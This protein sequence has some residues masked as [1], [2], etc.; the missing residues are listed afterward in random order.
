[1]R[2]S[3][4]LEGETLTAEFADRAEKDAESENNTDS[5]AV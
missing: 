2:F 1:V 5:T 4:D 3:C